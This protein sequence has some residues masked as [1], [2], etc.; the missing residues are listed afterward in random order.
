M[1]KHVKIAALLLAVAAG[2]AILGLWPD[3]APHSVPEP[4]APGSR[5][6]SAILP[7]PPAPA[8]DPQKVSLGRDL[9]TDRRLS[10]DDTV[11]CSSCHDLA[12]SGADNRQFSVGVGGAAGVM[13]SP[14]VF[15][16]AL[17]FAQFWDGRAA[18]LEEQ[19]S[20]PLHNR[21]EMA[22]DW[23]SVIAKLGKDK[24]L[25]RRFVEVYGQGPTDMLVIDAIATFERTLLT[26]DSPLDLYLRGDD[27][28]IGPKATAGLRLFTEL[29]C[30]GC[31]QGASLGGNLYQRFGIMA[32]PRPIREGEKA[33]L[34]RFNVTGKEED[35]NVFK[36]P[37]LRNVALTAPYF[38]HGG[39]ATL[40][41]AVAVMG[42]SQLGRTLTPDE[43]EAVVAFLNTLTGR[44]PVTAQ[45][46]A[47]P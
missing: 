14:T 5:S 2:I 22:T 39:A 31:H 26:P 6:S 4:R 37:G 30:V 19:V 46:V 25:V 18:T 40:A 23:P 21:I 9:F 35:R 29:G 7:L 47:Q 45:P 32:Q 28:A 44:Q 10:K 33:D 42:Q 8:L 17:H 38:H 15:N 20:G 34:G 11:A 24:A 1:S 41:D 16:A 27:K 36:V 3:N 12:A 43:V 13:N